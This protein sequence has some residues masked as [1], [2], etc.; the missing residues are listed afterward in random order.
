M[1][2]K[3]LIATLVAFSLLIGAGAC[4][5]KSDDDETEA[6]T[7]ATTTTESTTE[8]TTTTTE[9]TTTES[10]LDDMNGLYDP[11]IDLLVNPYTGI[12]DMDPENEG[13]RGVAIVINNHYAALPQRGISQADILY[14]YE[15]E[16]GQTRMLIGF[17]DINTVPEVGSLRS[18]RI[19]STDLAAGMNAVF[20]HYGRNARVP[21]HISQWGID[22]ID[23]NNCSAGAYSSAT[24]PDG[25]VNLPSGLFFWR[26]STWKSQRALEHTAVSDGAHIAEAI[27][28]YGISMEAEETPLLFNFVPGNSADLV[29]AEDCT[30]INVF[31]ST[32]NDDAEFTFD[33][34]T[35]LYTKTQY[36]GREQIDETTGDQ[37]AVTNIFVIFAEIHMNADGYT[38]DAFLEN[39]GTGYYVSDGKIVPITWTKPTPNDKITVYNEDGEEVEVN[40]G[41]SYVC[42]VDNDEIDNTTWSAEDTSDPDVVDE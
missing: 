35:G 39:G 13:N 9:A 7:E 12:Q 22:H 23:G 11:N 40:R 14:E 19:L 16:G 1:K 30:K 2:N 42:V 3:K 15:T 21:D 20:I 8:A 32:T 4:S 18:A 25:Y 5:K 34:I 17:A 28:H 31:F 38:I 24:A 36:G 41:V 6:T 10:V 29:G 26:D 37:I 27:E 33:P